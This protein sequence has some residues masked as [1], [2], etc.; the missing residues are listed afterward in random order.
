MPPLSP[1]PSASGPSRLPTSSHS[2]PPT[3]AR[4]AGVL[5][6]LG[7]LVLA[8]LA[9]LGH[10]LDGDDGDFGDPFVTALALAAVLHVVSAVWLLRRRRWWPLVLCALPPVLVL[11]WLVALAALGF[12]SGHGAD[13]L[14]VL[15]S[16]GPWLAISPA[17]AALALTPTSRRWVAERRAEYVSQ[18]P[19]HQPGA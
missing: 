11:G 1:H 9:L 8:A 17:A 7:A 19:P 16:L 18:P 6:V 5:G 14:D 4:I 10:A 13:G 12:L 2:G 3:T 15:L